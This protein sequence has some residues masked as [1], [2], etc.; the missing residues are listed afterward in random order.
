MFPRN[1]TFEE[2]N[3]KE[4][5]KLTKESNEAKD[6]VFQSIREKWRYNISFENKGT[7]NQQAT[8]EKQIE[9]G[10]YENKTKTCKALYPNSCHQTEKKKG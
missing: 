2:A 4:H 5:T 8:S 7:R 9:E 3:P 10:K 1:K 6:L